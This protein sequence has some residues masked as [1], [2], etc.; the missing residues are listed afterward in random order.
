M[1]NNSLKKIKKINPQIFIERPLG[2]S[3][4]DLKMIKIQSL[5]LRNLQVREL[6]RALAENTP[7]VVSDV[8]GGIEYAGVLRGGRDQLCLGRSRKASQRK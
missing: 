4:G 1:T 8:I 5:P 6:D 7:R 3:A 2:A